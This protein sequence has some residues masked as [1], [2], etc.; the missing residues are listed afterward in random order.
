MCKETGRLGIFTHEIATYSKSYK[1]FLAKEF[2]FE[3]ERHLQKEIIVLL[4]SGQLDDGMTRFIKSIEPLSLENY[5][6]TSY[7]RFL[8]DIRNNSDIVDE[9]ESILEDEPMT[10]DRLEQVSLIGR[11]D[12]Y[13]REEEDEF[14]DL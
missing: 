4:Q 13:F 7:I 8:M 1:I 2:T 5:T 12:L 10:K 6:S 9:M 11:D 14:D 3:K